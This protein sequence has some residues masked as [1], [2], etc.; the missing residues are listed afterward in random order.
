[1]AEDPPGLPLVRAVEEYLQYLELERHCSPGT[2]SEYRA[3]LE[4]FCTFAGEHYE[5]EVAV[6]DIDRDLL[7]AYQR[8]VGPGRLAPAPAGRWRRPPA[9]G[10]WSAYGASSAMPRHG[11]AGS[12]A[13]SG[14]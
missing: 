9:S 8:S 1:M 2:V 11:R 13:T 3:D 5:G 10:G 7:R 6:G 14:R 4:R 12:P